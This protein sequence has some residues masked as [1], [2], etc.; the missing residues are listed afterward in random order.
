MKYDPKIIIDFIRR[1]CYVYC[2]N[3][4]TIK[5]FFHSWTHKVEKYGE[6]TVAEI[7]ALVEFMDGK[8]EKVKPENIRFADGG[9]FGTTFFYPIDNLDKRGVSHD[10]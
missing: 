8:V 5:A 2:D 1:P 9:E 3:G 4:K 7:Y 10:V 6:Y